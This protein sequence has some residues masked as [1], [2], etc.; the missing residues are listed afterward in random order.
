MSLRLVAVLAG[1]LVALPASASVWPSTGERVAREL[2]STDPGLR[3]R[4]A[5]QLATLPRVQAGMLLWRALD[6]THA[7]V[8]LA[9]A[10]AA[11]TLRVRGAGARV[12]AWLNDPDRRVRIA[13]CEV[14]RLDPT[15]KAAPQL[16]RV[17]GD[18][19]AEVR[20]SAA[21]AL[22]V[23]GGPNAAAALLGHLDDSSMPVR[24]AVVT[25]LGRLG[26]RRAV[27][28][29][30]GKIQ[31]AEPSVRSAVARSLGELRDAR[32]V[33]ALVLAL[34][35]NDEGVRSAALEALAEL[36]DPGA[37]PSIAALLER[38]TSAVVR[39]AAIEALGRIGSD[40]AVA[41]LLRA[42]AASEPEIVEAAQL[43]LQSLGARAAPALTDCTRAG[44]SLE[45]ADR[46]AAALARVKSPGAGEV[47]SQA[48]LQGVI[49]PRAGLSALGELGDPRFLP[50]VLERLAASDPL[51]RRAAI[52]AALPLLAAAR[53][54]G[55]AVEPIARA[56]EKA[57]G[58]SAERL[59]L[60]TLL[61]RTG[62]PRA[63]TTLTPLAKGAEDLELR[64]TAL[65]A[66]GA[67]GPAGQ[68][69]VLLDALE[70]DEPSIRRAAALALNRSASPAAAR[71]ILDRL[72]Q[73]PEQ[74][75]ALL[76]LALAGAVS[77][78][79]DAKVSARLA[80]LVERTRGGERDALIEA[81][82]RMLRGGARERLVALL[83][84]S[85]FAADRA[86]LAEALAAHP[87]AAPTLNRL[88]KDLDA[89]VRANAVWAL[90]SA[91][92]AREIP[93]LRAALDDRDVAVSGNAAIALARVALRTRTS[94]GAA[95]CATLADPRS[96]VRA[97]ALAGLSLA[98]ARCG[99]GRERELLQ[100]DPSEVVRRAAAWLIR[101]APGE[102]SADQAA[103]DR[104][105]REEAA[106]E[107]ARACGEPL[108]PLPA[109]REPVTVYVVPVGETEPVPRAP[110]A[111]LLPDG[112][113]RMGNADR[114]GALFEAAAP[115][116]A[117]S[118]LVPA[119]LVR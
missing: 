34:R 37:T 18:P 118:L 7:D 99:S 62:S 21:E 80:D 109:S 24:R 59:A 81:T 8:R 5:E 25:A 104:C 95:L 55:R 57:R 90:G 78:S 65:E 38:D 54:E 49:T 111:L 84:S 29:L 100:H 23:T 68:D 26:E 28:P 9:A 36:S 101:R 48:L 119:A 43:A 105:K 75:R 22:A 67:L 93:A 69:V 50:S 94:P 106:G 85:P 60:V 31:D 2:H 51:V 73:R 56:L 14:L 116:G 46:C 33:S 82:S 107:V 13:A 3:R 76:V 61:G 83:R 70:D 91:G 39:A 27:V 44:P 112:S 11:R 42:L 63:V 52:D 12:L 89:S 71:P 98:R 64:Q 53:S 4:A 117:V 113:I 40:E 87:G 30:I 32:A 58:R 110:F 20:V 103:L 96:Y 86:K 72:E 35:D 45:I 16:G 10:G 47:L 1:A 108:P 114:R 79:N 92:G 66:L 41:A 77:R 17:L 6:D 74:D 15:S 97:N 115:A 19:D 88:A 102:R